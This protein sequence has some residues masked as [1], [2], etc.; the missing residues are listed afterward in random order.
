V[1]SG[2]VRWV[3]FRFGK[4]RQ[5][6]CGS[7]WWVEVRQGSAGVARCVRVGSG[8]LSRGLSGCGRLGEARLG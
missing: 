7:S 4:F 8:G 2:N 5:A 6:R 3:M 1:W